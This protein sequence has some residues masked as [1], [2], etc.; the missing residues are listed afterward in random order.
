MLHQRT[1]ENSGCSGFRPGVQQG[2]GERIDLS[3]EFERQFYG[4]VMLFTIERLIEL[5]YPRQELS[6]QRV[7]EILGRVDGEMR[8][9]YAHKQ[10][11]IMH[12]RRRLDRLF[13][14]S[15]SWWNGV[16]ELAASEENFRRFVHNIE[17]NFG[18]ESRA[19]RLVESRRRR[20]H[21]EMLEAILAYA[22]DRLA[23][24]EALEMLHAETEE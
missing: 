24:R 2:G 20:R 6:R 3:G 15:G 10:Q 4:D 11:L 21:A 18:P 12:K 7:G 17:S 19:L 22:D 16:P 23:W 5:G 13:F 8:Q 9:R 1:M 14:D